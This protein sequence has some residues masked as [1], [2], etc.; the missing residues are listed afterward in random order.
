MAI[1][2]EWGT[3]IISVPQSFLTFVSGVNY[4]LDTGAFRIA[5]RALEDDEAGVV[6]LPTHSHN[7]VVTLGGLDYARIIEMIN[8]YT[9]TFEETGTPYAVNLT[10]SNNNILDVVNL[11]TVAVRS[12][13]S[14]G[15][16]DL[17]LANVVWNDTRA[18]TLPIFV[19]LK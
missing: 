7:T 19:G 4:T 5:L 12:N 8:G 16:T 14:A 17:N 13:N 11:G 1:S 10:G 9:I 18:L 15:L 3:K 2:I 6:N